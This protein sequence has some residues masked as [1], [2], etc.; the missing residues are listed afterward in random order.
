MNRK[1]FGSIINKRYLYLMR[2]RN[3][4]N[5]GSIILERWHYIRTMDS[6]SELVREKIP[7]K[8]KV[9]VSAADGS[10]ALL[11]ALIG[12]GALT[13]YFTR[14]R[15]LDPGYASIV[16]ILFG[17]WNAI[18][19][20][21]FGW[22]SDKTKN[23]LGRRIP[24]IRFGAPLIAIFY[25]L[26]WVDWPGSAG[27]QIYLFL[28]FFIFLFFYD[29]LYTAVATALW[30]M[31][32]EM[33]VSNKVRGSIFIWKMIFSIIATVL[34]LVAVPLI[35]PDV[36][37][38]ISKFEAYRNFNYVLGALVGLIVFVSTYFYKENGYQREEQQFGF[39]ES[40]VASF[41]NKPFLIF[42]A[43]SF[44]IIYVQTGLMQGVLYYYDELP[45][46]MIATFPIL[47]IGA[48]IGIILYSKNHEAWGVQKCMQIMLGSFAL[49]CLFILLFGRFTLPTTIGFFG[50][51]MGFAGG[52]FLIPMMMGDTFDYDEDVTGKRREGMYSGVN[53]FITKPAISIAQALFLSIIAA[54]GYDQTLSKGMQSSSAE[55]GII[56][57]WMLVPFILLTTCFLIMKLY[58][59]AG[60]KWK[61]TKNKLALIHKE[62][63]REFLRKLGFTLTDDEKPLN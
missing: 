21:L 39:I 14:L 8:S 57:A 53:S 47:F 60:P 61:E 30:I 46:P 16:L 54:Y 24:Y 62:K 18:N 45:V 51:G 59:L 3:R 32:F 31:P 38:P 13:Y 48:I 23:K 34:P 37:D 20:P 4:S 55:T 6:N 10:V 29:V 40:L 42:L 52:Y 33:A 7:L 41:K 50:V 1:K 58:P 49:G 19:D 56:V 36:N 15:G 44:T 5:F 28:Q 26:C 11:Q 35:Q 63:E 43:I 17:V 22:I 2:K 12:G 25:A 27:N 9:W